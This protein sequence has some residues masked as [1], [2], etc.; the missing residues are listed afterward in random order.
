MLW[1]SLWTSFYYIFPVVLSLI[2]NITHA[3]AV[4]G[5]LVLNIVQTKQGFL[6]V[7]RLRQATYP[8][9][10]GLSFKIQQA[11]LVKHFKIK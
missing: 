8:V 5:I 3:G 4:L 6:N 10:Y 2:D 1:H 11:F 7:L 9:Q